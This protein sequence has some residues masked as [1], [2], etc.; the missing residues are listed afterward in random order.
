MRIIVVLQD[1]HT[2]QVTNVKTKKVVWKFWAKKLQQ[3]FQNQLDGAFCQMFTFLHIFV[4]S[5]Y[6]GIHLYVSTLGKCFIFLGLSM[7]IYKIGCWTISRNIS[8]K[9]W[10]ETLLVVPACL[11]SSVPAKDG[12]E[13]WTVFFSLSVFKIIAVWFGDFY[14][15]WGRIVVLKW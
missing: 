4:L 3:H 7:R 1:M 8:P 5:F 12:D 6:C 14:V 9:T 10:C 11:W 15:T 13:H 2:L